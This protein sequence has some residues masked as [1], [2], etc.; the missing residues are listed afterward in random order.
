MKDNKTAL[1]LNQEAVEAFNKQKTLLLCPLSYFS[2]QLKK[3]EMNYETKFLHLFL[4][5]RSK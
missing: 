5:L 4:V 1:E 3:A 2:R